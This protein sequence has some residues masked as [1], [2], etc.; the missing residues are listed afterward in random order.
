[1]RRAHD[2]GAALNQRFYFRKVIHKG[3]RQANAPHRTHTV[4]GRSQNDTTH[5]TGQEQKTVPKG[6]LTGFAAAYDSEA[7][8]AEDNTQNYYEEMSINQII[9][10][11]VHAPRTTPHHTM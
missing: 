5:D 4:C 1:M 10:G 9:N 2:R 11:D 3:T 6:E 8:A 7:A